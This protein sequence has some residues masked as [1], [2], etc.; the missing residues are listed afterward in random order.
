[1]P[2]EINDYE[3]LDAE[4][5]ISTSDKTKINDAIARLCAVEMPLDESDEEQVQQ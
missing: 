2:L 3:G 1:M 5:S 4:L